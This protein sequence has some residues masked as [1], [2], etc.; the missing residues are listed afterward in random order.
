MQFDSTPRSYIDQTRVLDDDALAE[1]AMAA[2]Y[3][4]DSS[5]LPG[6]ISLE[7]IGLGLEKPL[8]LSG[9]YARKCKLD[10]NFPSKADERRLIEQLAPTISISQTI[11]LL[12]ALELTSA[13]QL[14][15]L[16][17]E[18]ILPG[19]IAAALERFT[20]LAE[21][22]PL[23]VDELRT[24][25]YIE[26]LPLLLPAPHDFT[27][28]LREDAAEEIF[29]QRHIPVGPQTE[30][31]SD[32]VLCR[33][34]S[35]VLCI[36]AMNALTNRGD[37]VA[38]M[39]G[40]FEPLVAMVDASGRNIVM[41]P[42]AN[43]GMKLTPETFQEAIDNAGAGVIK[44]LLLVNPS[45]VF[46]TC[47]S[48]QE[49]E[50][51]S[52]IAVKNEIKIINDELYASLGD[53]SRVSKASKKPY[54]SLASL[55]VHVDGQEALMYDHSITIQGTSKVIPHINPKLGFA[56]SGDWK[57]IEAM[58]R[59][60]SSAGLLPSVRHVF[61]VSSLWPQTQE[62]REKQTKI[63]SNKL[64]ALKRCL[65]TAERETGRA[66]FFITE[67]PK[68]GFFVGMSASAKDLAKANVYDSFDLT[69]Y[70]WQT[71]GIDT[72]PLSG[73]FVGETNGNITV[74]INVSEI[75]GESF[76]QKLTER[77][78]LLSKLLAGNN[79]PKLPDDTGYYGFVDDDSSMFGSISGAMV[80]YRYSS[81]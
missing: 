16:A 5:A 63:Y 61:S 4:V 76:Q 21:K 59:E 14:R 41:L 17:N 7:L 49:L 68:G 77:L 60:V 66:V 55:K 2:F 19:G 39:Q 1:F 29:R 47:N 18:V 38:V 13:S 75:E 36:A 65:A 45:G 25:Q 26:A 44:A 70:L 12:N 74:R 42:T 30:H 71:A 69:S 53:L 11:D 15:A 32:M 78:T 8:C 10:L 56:V 31:V 37:S 20:A 80:V 79:P 40:T 54:V 67:P 58:N 27:R 23:S 3:S 46:G 51:I 50:E 81:S 72:R 48:K 33:G 43:T 24:L 9:S 73:M 62:I 57:A 52:K 64:R 28:K 22:G 34:T 35:Q 6:R